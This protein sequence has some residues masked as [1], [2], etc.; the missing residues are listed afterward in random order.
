MA[1]S[2]VNSLSYASTNVTTSAYVVLIASTVTSCKKLEIVDSST[3]LIK[4]ATG[5][6]GSEVDIC[7]AAI[8]GTVIVDQYIPQGT[9]ISIKA[10]DASATSGYIAVSLIP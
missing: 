1:G 6:T 3:K 9:Q 8:S 7:T 2:L 5:A 10:I 4:L